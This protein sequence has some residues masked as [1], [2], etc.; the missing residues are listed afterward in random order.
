MRLTEPILTGYLKT[1][2]S[3]KEAVDEA[4]PIYR[5]DPGETFD[6]GDSGWW[7]QQAEGLLQSGIEF[8]VTGAITGGVTNAAGKVL[9]GL[10]KTSPQVAQA[11]KTVTNA[12]A[13]NYVEIQDD[14]NR[15]IQYHLQQWS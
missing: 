2:K 4:L 1:M 11:I 13:M 5:T 14:V 6:V 15:G 3:G 12:T 7:F 8:G 9:S 10:S